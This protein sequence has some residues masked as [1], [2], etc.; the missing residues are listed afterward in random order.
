MEKYAFERIS[1][2]TVKQLVPLYYSAF[3]ASVPID[4][5]TKK[6]ET[7]QFG[8][9]YIGF[10]ARDVISD[11]IAAFYGVFPLVGKFDGNQ[12]LIAQSGD[13][14]T[15]PKH[16][17][18]GLFT[19]LAKL[20]YDLAQREGI[21]FV[22]GFP[23]K[24]SFPG[25]INKLDWQHYSDINTYVIKSGSMPIDKFFK[26]FGRINFLY[27]AYYRNVLKK[28]LSDA[29]PE[30]SLKNESSKVGFV[31]HDSR[32][33]SYKKYSTSYVLKIDDVFCNVKIDGR[34]WVGDISVCEESK[35]YSV[36]SKLL[37]IARKIGCSTIHISAFNGTALDQRMRKKYSPTI[38]NPVGCIDLTADKIGVKFAY[39]AFDFDTF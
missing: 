9:S 16:Q 2:E 11:T 38:S 28:W 33:Y 19:K 35:F 27:H 31:V 20:T 8:A 21:V 3:G 10:L 25:F 7:S 22:F 18:K 37:I 6:F 39:Q 15:H 12:V 26:K 36:I 30:N 1:V 17:G 34:L 13:T 23:N 14:M 4:F 29:S 32:F 24:N 5:I